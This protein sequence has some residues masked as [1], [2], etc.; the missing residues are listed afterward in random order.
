[1]W[2]DTGSSFVK[3]TR[4]RYMTAGE[5]ELENG[6]FYQKINDDPTEQI[7]AKN[8]VIADGM[9][10]KEEISEKVANF[11]KDGEPRL[12]KYYH[13]LKTHKIPHDIGNPEEWL[14][15]NGFPISGFVSGC[16]S[17]TEKLSGFVDYFLQTGVQNLDTYLRDTK[18]TLQVIE[19]INGKIDDGEITLDGVAVVSLDVESMYNNMSEELGTGGFKEYLENRT[20][21]EVSTNAIL[22]ALDLCLK[23][24]FFVF[25]K[26]VYK[27]VSGVGT[28]VKLAPT[29]TC[30]GLG[31]YE[32]I[33]FSSDQPLLERILL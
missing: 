25:N 5:T 19:D 28:G 17:A 9:L 13:L 31:K 15:E 26:Q 24:N 21:K 8:D 27:Q 23:S 29:Y 12:S 14:S 33:V 1:M 20:E 6:N 7:K 30:L 32:K 22:T 16:G 10:C 11:L 18:H 2:E 4:D 3:L